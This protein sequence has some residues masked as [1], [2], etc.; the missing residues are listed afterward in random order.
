MRHRCS[1]LQQAFLIVK[2]TEHS[3]E[4]IHTFVEMQAFF[5]PR[6]LSIINLTATIVYDNMLNNIQG[7]LKTFND[8]VM[9]P[10]KSIVR[11]SDIPGACGFVGP[12]DRDIAI[13]VPLTPASFRFR[14]KSLQGYFVPGAFHWINI[15]L[16]VSILNQI[17]LSA[18]VPKLHSDSKQVRDK[19]IL[20]G[21]VI[22]MVLMSISSLTIYVGRLLLLL[23]VNIL[24]LEILL[25]RTLTIKANPHN[26]ST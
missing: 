23:I 20:V 24:T 25:P 2:R 9:Q 21:A 3:V 1:H 10:N 16:I 22:S 7:V 6:T 8:L 14:L 17:F 13:L 4:N 5:L 11:G 26:V 15:I 18:N 12:R 19:Y